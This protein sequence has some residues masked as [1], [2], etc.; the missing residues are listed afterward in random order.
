MARLVDYESF[1]ENP[2]TLEKDKEHFG[3]ILESKG[4]YV[5]R[6]TGEVIDGGNKYKEVDH[7]PFVKMFNEALP[8]FQGL[9]SK[10]QRVLYDILMDLRK[11]EDEVYLNASSLAQKHGLSNSR[12]ILLG[13]KELLDNDII[14][15]KADRDMYFVNVRYIF[16]GDRAKYS[17]N[18]KRER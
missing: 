10:A 2:F 15:R 5:D 11:E 18:L 4:H 1:K 16:N 14:C 13:I 3:K 17:R 7:K 12:D 6:F 8:I 9:K